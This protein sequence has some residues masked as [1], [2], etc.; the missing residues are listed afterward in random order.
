MANTDIDLNLGQGSE[1]ERF[2]THRIDWKDL[3]NNAPNGESNGDTQT[4]QLWPLRTGT[5]V[6]DIYI[7]S[8]ENF[9]GVGAV[10]TAQVGDATDPNGFIESFNLLNPS[11]TAKVAIPNGAYVD[12]VS[13]EAT[14]SNSDTVTVTTPSAKKSKGYSYAE[15]TEP[16]KLELLLTPTGGKLG[17]ATSGRI[18]IVADII[19]MNTM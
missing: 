10:M 7:L 11:A 5:I 14:D 2:L 18:L 4:Y 3:V 15:G 9:V 16:V 12:A 19:F 13:D 1:N 6:R 8:E 17:S